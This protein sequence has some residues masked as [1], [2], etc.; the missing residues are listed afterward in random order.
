[1]QIQS[2]PSQVF[3]PIATGASGSGEV[4]TDERWFSGK[5]LAF[6]SQET[7]TTGQAF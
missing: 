1:M 4:L 7:T 2:D 6:I 3:I 5:N